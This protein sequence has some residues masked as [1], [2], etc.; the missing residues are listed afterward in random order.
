MRTGRSTPHSRTVLEE[1]SP[2]H[3]PPHEPVPTENNIALLNY[4]VRA[5]LAKALLRPKPG[6]CFHTFFLN[7]CFGNYSRTLA[8]FGWLVKFSQNHS[9][10]AM[11]WRQVAN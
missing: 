8:S 5:Q 9:A 11:K 6:M 4:V 2:A 7:A 1:Q 10:H 3:K